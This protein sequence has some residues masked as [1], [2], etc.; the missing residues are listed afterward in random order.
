MLGRFQL[1]VRRLE[2]CERRVEGVEL[3]NAGKGP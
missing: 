1:A 3:R 2:A